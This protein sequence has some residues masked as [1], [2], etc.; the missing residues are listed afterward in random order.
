MVILN[1]PVMMRILSKNRHIAL[2]FAV[3]LAAAPIAA[4]Q[5]AAAERTVVLKMPD[6]TCGST[7][8]QVQVFLDEIPGILRYVTDQDEHAA[9]VTFDDAKVNLGQIKDKLKAN[10]FPVSGESFPEAE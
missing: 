4:G 10:G 9:T 2:A 7:E 5:A 8:M 3:S 6:L 1:Y